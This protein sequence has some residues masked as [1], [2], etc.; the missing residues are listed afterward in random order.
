[1]KSGTRI[2]PQHRPP[3]HATSCRNGHNLIPVGAVYLTS[4]GK[5]R[6]VA[7]HK[8]WYARNKATLRKVREAAPR[9]PFTRP[10]MTDKDDPQTTLV[11]LALYRELEFAPRYD[12]ADIRARIY[13]LQHSDN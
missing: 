6:C 2:G 12:H 9:S 13:Q 7:C 1:M 10:H 5:R 8:Q 3:K 11:I 4:D